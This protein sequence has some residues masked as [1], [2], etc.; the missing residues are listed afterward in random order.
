MKSCLNKQKRYPI[1]E[2]SMLLTI[3]FTA[4]SWQ[5]L[6][7]KRRSAV[8]NKKWD[9]EYT[10]IHKLKPRR[11]SYL[12]NFAVIS[13]ID[14][15]PRWDKLLTFALNLADEFCVIFPD[16]KYD[17][18]NPLVIGKPEFTALPNL[19]MGRWPNM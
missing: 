2:K 15:F 4:E 9:K 17:P 1:R 11:Y 3:Q 16:G 19:K 18:E 6:V 5:A 12:N 10:G 13:S 7:E 8:T 14:S